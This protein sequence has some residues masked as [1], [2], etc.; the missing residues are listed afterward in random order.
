MLTTITMVLKI[1]HYVLRFLLLKG[2][3][4]TGS[5]D[6]PTWLGLGIKATWLGLVY[7]YG[8]ERSTCLLGLHHFTFL[9]TKPGWTICPDVSHM[10]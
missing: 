3:L 8:K 1:C 10:L 6:I 2:I 7:S 9:A 5:G 4:S